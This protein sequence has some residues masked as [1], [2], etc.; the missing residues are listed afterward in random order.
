M[1]SSIAKFHRW[2]P[3]KRLGL[4]GTER[5][6]RDRGS[7]TVGTASHSA[8]APH[9]AG[10]RG[11]LVLALG[12]VYAVP[13]AIDP[14]YGLDDPSRIANRALDDKFDAAVARTRDRGGARRQ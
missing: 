1:P 6:D 4:A 10:S 7:R 12:A 14:V 8:R 3:P 11:R 2:M 5:A 13:R 9:R